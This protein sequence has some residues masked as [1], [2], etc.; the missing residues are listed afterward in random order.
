M[1]FRELSEASGVT[2]ASIKF[3]LREGLL[4]SGRRLNPTRAE[5]GPAH[6]ERLNLIQA[7]R[8][9]VGLNLVQIGSIVSAIDSGLDTLELLGLVQRTVLGLEVPGRNENG[10]GP[11]DAVLSLRG[12]PDLPSAA[13]TALDEQLN[14]MAGLGLEVPPEVLAAYSAAA[15]QAAAVDIG[16]V[17]AADSPDALVRTAAVGMHLYS[18]LLLR[19]LALAQASHSMRH[20]GSE[21]ASPA[22]GP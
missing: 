15:D 13:R 17:A 20:Y 5:Y 16:Y 18:G 9:I 1:Q 3:Y 19:M 21:P 4:P 11:A 14:L 22:A 10:G 2:A 6:L 8:R 12:W 7:L